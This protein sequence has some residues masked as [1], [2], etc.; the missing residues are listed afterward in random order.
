MKCNCNDVVEEVKSAVIRF[1]G[2]SGDGMQTVGERLSTT[3]ALAG[4]DIATFPDYPSEIRAPV[5]TIA[6]VSGF[7]LQIG[8]SKIRTPGDRPDALV[9][10]NPAALKV[11]L[12][13]LVDHGLLIVNTADFTE[14][15]LK[16]A[17][18]TTNPLEDETLE[19]KYQ[20]VRLNLNELIIDALESTSLKPKDRLRCKNFLALGFVFWVFDQDCSS[21]IKWFEKKWGSKPE[22]IEAN[23]LALNTGYHLGETTEINVPKYHV[24]SA[25]LEKGIYRS[26]TGNNA[27]ALGLLT[28]SQLCDR[29]LVLG[30]YPITPATGILEYLAGYKS[31]GVKTVQAEDEI[32]GIGVAIGAS[33]AGALAAT[34]TSGPGLALKS[35]FIGLAVMSELPLVI[36]DVQRGGPSTGLPT[37]T[38][39]SDLFQAMYG[40]N[41]E[42]PVPIV[43]G[44]SPGD[45][46]YAAIEAARIALK[47]STP[48]LLLTD[49]YIA[50]G[51]EPWKVPDV[52]KLD[53]IDVPVAKENQEYLPYKRDEKTL[54]RTLAI[55]GT[56]G[57]EH[58]LGGLEKD[59]T[60]MVSHDGLNH[61]K[62]VKLRKQKIE[63]IA[64]S[65]K[66]TE[67]FCKE[68]GDVLVLGWGG[69]WG[70]ITAGV[71]RHCVR[72][73]KVGALCLSNIY[74]LPNDLK[75]IM[76]R[77]KHVIVP[78]LNMGQLATILR[79]EYLI[80]VKSITKV[81]G[82][83]FSVEEIDKAIIS[84]LEGK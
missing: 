61:E 11:N 4:S 51:T 7:Q 84:V 20:I 72:G 14:A 26:I 70:A 28:A 68:E 43:A 45:C 81:Q 44:K 3:S 13:D 82:K 29:E 8:S 16:K 75:E 15:N 6:G 71:E 36:V 59:E 48:V 83:Q 30:S 42:C 53:K 31:L 24:G 74:P 52:S 21:T 69:T 32:A 79:S 67:V 10:M 62:M 34:T 5:G 19:A 56:P 17:G 55:P 25:P 65:Y 18:Y 58:R 22:L 39:Q 41:G 57:L 50:N 80:D 12:K 66:P 77:F 2:D 49:G 46:Y 33:F 47:Y 73:N 63:G 37:K 35:E 78:E 1:A 27:T 54:S 76:Q 23:T 9:A 40:R 64:N 38:E 60:G